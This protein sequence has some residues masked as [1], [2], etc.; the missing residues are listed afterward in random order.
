MLR[1][2]SF[3]MKL[4]AMYSLIMLALVLTSFAG[5]YAYS[6]SYVYR[7]LN[8]A[9]GREASSLAQQVDNAIYTA[10][11]L[12]LQIKYNPSI[13]DTFYYLQFQPDARNYFRQHEVVALKIKDTINSITGIDPQ[14]FNRVSIMSKTGAFVSVGAYTDV[15]QVESKSPRQPWFDS[16]IDEYRLLLPTHMDDWDPAGRPVISLIRKMESNNLLYALVEIQLP[17]TSLQTML[18]PGPNAPGKRIVLHAADNGAIYESSPARADAVREVTT[19]RHLK[20][21]GW[22]LT[23]SQPEHTLLAPVRN[24]GYLLA[25]IGLALSLV[26]LAMMYI[27][28]ARAVKP[29]VRLSRTMAQVTGD[30][31]TEARVDDLLGHPDSSGTHNEV[32]HLYRSFRKML[33]RL[34]ESKQL[35]IEAHSRELKSHLLALQAQMNPHFLYNTLTLI[36]LMG[37]NAGNND[38]LSLTNSVVQMLRYVTYDSDKQVTLEDEL[39]YTTHYLKIMEKR[40]GEHLVW[41]LQTEGELTAALLPKLTIQPMVE[42][43]IKHGFQGKKYPWNI[44]I[45]VV[46]RDGEGWM[47]A[48]EDD[49]KG[50]D[51]AVLRQFADRRSALRSGGAASAPRDEGSGLFN[52]YARL[53]YSFGEKLLFEP[54]NRDAGGAYVRVGRLSSVA[55]SIGGTFRWFEETKEVD[56]T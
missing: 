55:A 18:D 17:Y 15:S 32:A 43:C 3:Q 34:E 44:A 48:V 36:G 10:D 33:D 14:M 31:T 8:D 52:T 50:F 28:T 49:G 6:R 39:E 29:L 23:V 2:R 37:R 41:T 11:R 38:I 9:F 30:E 26:S 24:T 27:S 25:A 47:F 12:A 16:L 40:Y 54:G 19:Q 46:Q 20:Y 7:T 22:T 1:T 53:Y 4:F 42:N 51:A 5:F 35:A 13:Q 45:R 21:T 56:A